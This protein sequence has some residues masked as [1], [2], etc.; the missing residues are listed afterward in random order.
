[1]MKTAP[2]KIL[3]KY[4][5]AFRDLVNT[6]NMSSDKSIKTL[7]KL[8]KE[9]DW[10]FICTAMDTIGDS[11]SAIKSF[12][13]F[14]L[15]GPTRYN[16]F[17][18]RYLRLYGVLNATYIQQEGIYNLYKLTNVQNSGE[19]YD[20]IKDLKVRDAR[21]KLGAHSNDYLNRKSGKQ[22]SF[23]PIQVELSGFIC[24]CINNSTNEIEEFD[25][26]EC[27]NEHLQLMIELLDKTYE[28]TINTLYKTKGRTRDEFIERLSDLR[29]IRSGGT[30]RIGSD[31]TK[32][33]MN[34]PIV[35]ASNFSEDVKE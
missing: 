28:K 34:V 27:L 10:G 33:R 4:C 30:I 5:D 7:L 12:L 6:T 25:L 21:H 15:D 32:L 11:C 9:E 35:V 31:G 22:E 2:V 20:R 17:G 24:Q 13:R 18:E 29:F 3:E 8:N 19:V 1:M 16:D 26:L 23:V 14:G